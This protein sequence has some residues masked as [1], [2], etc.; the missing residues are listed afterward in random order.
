MK[1][2]KFCVLSATLMAAS[3]AVLAAEVYA[4]QPGERVIIEGRAIPGD[5][6]ASG[7]TSLEDMRLADDVAF[8]LHDSR[9]LSRPGMT[10]TVVAN[11]GEVT[12]SGSADNYE[13]A[14]RA[15][16][17]ARAAAGPHRVVGMIS[18]TSG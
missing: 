16:R 6:I 5:G 4:V 14:Q 1:T 3:G 15:E 2:I 18:T 7:G 17:I 10:A 9:R 12:I 13:Q 8:A 11:R